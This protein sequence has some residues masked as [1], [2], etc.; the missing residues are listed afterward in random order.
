MSTVKTFRAKVADELD[1]PYPSALVAVRQWSQSAQETGNS[2][3][4]EEDYAEDYAVEAIAYRANYW[5]D[6]QAQV[7]G[8]KSRPLINKENTEEPQLFTVDLK[9]LQSLQVLNS[10]MAPAD[11]RFRL[12]ELDVTRRF[13]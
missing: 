3:D 2:S 7:N 8:L 9:H 11:K 12:I 5:P 1:W 4:C 6:I 10:S 13:A